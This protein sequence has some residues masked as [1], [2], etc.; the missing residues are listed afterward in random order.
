MW[1]KGTFL[2]VRLAQ[3]PKY[4]GLECTASEDEIDQKLEH[5]C[6]RDIN[7]LQETGLISLGPRLACTEFGDAMARYYVKFHT[8]K[9]FLD[10]RAR[11][12]LS[13]I[14]RHVESVT[15]AR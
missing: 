1:L 5:I 4:Y 15:S 10:L 11:A 14:V 2:Y 6:A 8:M 9:T 12:T 13:E 7:L 3:N